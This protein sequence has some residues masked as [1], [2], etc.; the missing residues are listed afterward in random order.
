LAFSK[1]H[2]LI[3]VYAAG[4]FQ[5][6][7]LGFSINYVGPQPVLLFKVCVSMTPP[8]ARQH[9]DSLTRQSSS[10]SSANFK[11][12]TDKSGCPTVQRGSLIL[13]EFNH[14]ATKQ[15]PVPLVQIKD[16]CEKK[17]TKVAK[18]PGTFSL[19]RHI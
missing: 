10:K 4:R 3:H 8:P 6:T 7:K 14:L 16:F 19:N 15:N 12:Q 9:G 1:I 2:V 17:Y 11:K 13:G 5:C 18:S